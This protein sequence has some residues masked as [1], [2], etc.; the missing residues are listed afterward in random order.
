MIGASRADS[1]TSKRR[2]DQQHDHAAG[3]F[4]RFRLRD[5]DDQAQHLGR[6]QNAHRQSEEFERPLGV[7]PREGRKER[8]FAGKIFRSEIARLEDDDDADEKLQQPER[9]RQIAEDAGEKMLPRRPVKAFAE[10]HARMLQVALTPA[11]VANRQVDQAIRGMAMS[12]YV[13]AD[14]L[15]CALSGTSIRSQFQLRFQFSKRPGRQISRNSTCSQVKYFRAFRDI[16]WNRYGSASG[17][18]CQTIQFH[19]GNDVVI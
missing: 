3:A 7:E 11:A 16:R 6:E 15:L 8:K 5:G 9:R 12:M 1:T 19:F 14:V 18:R 13:L 10:Q 4:A 17:L 2:R